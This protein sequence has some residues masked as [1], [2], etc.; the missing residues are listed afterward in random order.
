ML[1]VFFILESRAKSYLQLPAVNSVTLTRPASSKCSRCA[2]RTEY[3]IDRPGALKSLSPPFHPL[4]WRIK[5][6]GVNHGAGRFYG[7][8]EFLGKALLPGT[9]GFDSAK[10]TYLATPV[11]SV[12]LLPS[13]EVNYSVQS[14][15]LGL[16]RLVHIHA[17]Q[18]F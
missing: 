17:L 9:R 6:L 18:D 14:P 1:S 13:A 2:R 16:A 7:H 11:K 5:T 3:P 15:K 4:L 12:L 10:L 8:Q